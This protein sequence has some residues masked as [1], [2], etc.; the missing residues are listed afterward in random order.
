MVTTTAVKPDSLKPEPLR[1]HH[2]RKSKV[3]CVVLGHSIDAI[4]TATVMVTLGHSVSLYADSESLQH[5]LTNYTFEH[6]QQALWQLYL[7]QEDIVVKPLTEQAD[8]VFQE[9]DADVYW[10]FYTDMPSAWREQSVSQAQQTWIN[11][12]N[13]SHIP[14]QTPVILSGISTLGVF[15]E[16]SQQCLRPWV[17]YV[18]FVFLQDGNAYP[19]MLSPKL[20]LM[21]EKTPNSVDK[22]AL[23]QPLMT[24]ANKS[25][26]S[27]IATIEFSRSAIMSMLATRVSFMNEWSRLADHQGV[28][29]LEVADIMGLDARIGSS[30]LK[31]GW[32]FGGQTLPAEID[33]LQQTID[34]T[35]VDNRLMQAVTL[36]NDDQKELIFRKFWQYFDG[37]IEQKQVSIL[38]ASYKSGSGR[39]SSAAIH[40]LLHLLWSYNITTYVYAAE[41]EGELAQLYPDQP[42]LV[43]MPTPTEHL[44][45]SDALFVLSWPSMK[46]LPIGAINDVV[47]PVF[48]AQN[49]FSTTQIQAL[50]GDYRGIGRRK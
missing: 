4:T 32:G 18:P 27:D 6:Q 17:Y 1:S 34:N 48:D 44:Q 28:D 33:A 49:A 7:S 46:R 13:E 21:G 26:I 47:I 31:A 38:G 11:Q 9:S 30:Y 14:T 42:L 25:Y 43:F 3:H 2:T 45:D 10:I 41:A 29:I 24:Q 22:I 23:L 12:L 16:L 20:W 36:I 50:V 19:S 37:A 39:T 8:G 35:Q 5:T 15:A 40:P